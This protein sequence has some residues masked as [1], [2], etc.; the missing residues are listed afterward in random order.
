MKSPAK[1]S[2]LRGFSSNLHGSPFP[3]TKSFKFQNS[4][5]KFKFTGP[6]I[7]TPSKSFQNQIYWTCNSNSQEKFPKW[8]LLALWPLRLE[9]GFQNQIHWPCDPCS[10]EKVSKIKLTG[11]ATPTS[12]ETL[13][14][15]KSLDHPPQRLLV[16]AV[17]ISRGVTPHSG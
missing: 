14:R 17:T 6:E 11:P 10:Q 2:N 1:I 8:N 16:V 5:S 4:G 13:F 15:M 9:K 3:G 12:R 7:P